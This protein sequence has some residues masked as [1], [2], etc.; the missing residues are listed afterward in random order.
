ME[1]NIAENLESVRAGIKESERRS[2]RPAGSVELIAVT[3]THPPE[4]VRQ[5]IEAGQLLF[6]EN[7]V[8]ETKAKIPELPAKLR[9]HL[10][11]HL[12]G[13]KLRPAL[14]IFDV[15]QAR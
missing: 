11:G 10:I 3:K 14:Q 6:G 1:P 15:V 5:A 7:R 8:Q 2:G 9:R 4:V 12:E 13:N